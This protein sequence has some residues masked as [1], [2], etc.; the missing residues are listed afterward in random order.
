MSIVA[1]Q[2]CHPKPKRQKPTVDKAKLKLLLT[3]VV[4]NNNV[5]EFC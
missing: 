2:K 4:K 3:E 5:T 1:F